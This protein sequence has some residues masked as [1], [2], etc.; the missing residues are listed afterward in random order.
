MSKV[1]VLSHRKGG[2]GKTTTTIHL[3]TGVASLGY[4]V[5]AIDLDPQGNLGE[6]LGLGQ[7]D[8]T[9]NLLMTPQPEMLIDRVLTPVP[10]YPKLKIVRSNDRTLWAERSLSDPS[11]PR[12]LADALR[13]IIKAAQTMPSS[14]GRAPFVMLDTPPGLGPTQVAALSVA[15]YLI[16][17]IHATFASETGIPKM[18]TEILA[19]RDQ[20]GSAAQLLGLLP[21]R[22]KERTLEHQATLES[23]AKQFGSQLIYPTVRETIRLEEC[24]SRGLPIWDYDRE[25]G[26]AQDYAKVLL[27]FA[28]DVGIPVK[29]GNGGNGR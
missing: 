4:P 12:S 17:P 24:P 21:T 28:R 9:C 5:V 15:D 20:T 1:L 26:G 8:D 16:I 13:A 25:S 10:H 7:A 27:R 23:L 6:F 2:V 19:I 29:N 22:F 3:A 18:I 14:D 11:A